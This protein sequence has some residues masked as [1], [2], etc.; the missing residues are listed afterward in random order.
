MIV[1]L[2]G[3]ITLL[4]SCKKEE[5]EPEVPTPAPSV[6]VTGTAWTSI[7][8]SFV[9]NERIM[10]IGTVNGEMIMSFVD[11]TDPSAYYLS[12]QLTSWGTI[13]KHVMN[14]SGGGGGFEKIEVIGNEVYGLG[15]WYTNGLWQFDVSFFNNSDWNGW[16]PAGAYGTS[17]SALT[18]LGGDRIE[19]YSASPYVRSTS[20]TNYPDLEATGNLSIN[21]LVIYNGEL[22]AAGD[23]D[24][25]NGTTLNNIAKWDGAA[26]VPLANGV[27][28]VIYDMEILD[29]DLIAAGKFTDA[30]GNTNC[31]KIAKWNGTSWVAMGTGLDG[32]LNGVR[33][34]FVYE[35]QLFVGGDFDG[36]GSVLSA[37]I[38]KWKGGN[39]IGL[40]NTITDIIGEIGVYDGHLY[41]ANAF[42][43]QGANFLMKLE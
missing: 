26:W 25:Y 1:A 19:G 39:W 12:G 11:Y 17:I 13:D 30:D 43:I 3:S 27:N 32:G 10:A 29:G 7:A 35:S 23:F 37:N 42:N 28:G 5:V 4:Q 38:I 40:P 20:G 36:S 31:S 21:D 41:I 34:L 9:A 14:Y 22:I 16:D 15:T 8:S 24:S 18:K 6:N 33:K 2:V